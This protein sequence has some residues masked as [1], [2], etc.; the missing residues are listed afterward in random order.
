MNR[1]NKTNL[2]NTVD[3]TNPQK[4]LLNTIQ[5][6][7]SESQGFVWIHPVHSTSMY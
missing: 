7:E 1:I 2:F 4:N 6:C 5:I 3:K